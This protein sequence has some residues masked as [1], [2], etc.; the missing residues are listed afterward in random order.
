MSGMPGLSDLPLIGRL[1]ASN[2]KESQQTDV[3][4]TL[5]PHIV[6]VLELDEDDLRPVR[7]GRDLGGS[8]A[9]GQGLQGFPNPPRDPRE[10]LQLPAALT[11]KPVV[12]PTLPFPQPLQAPLPGKPVPPPKKPGGGGG[13]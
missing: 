2:H 13:R 6:R 7:L 10:D 11:D 9:V 1:F 5:T 12:V 3:I 8:A 4:L